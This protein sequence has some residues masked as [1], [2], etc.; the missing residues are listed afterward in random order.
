MI[1]FHTH[2]GLAIFPD[3]GL[4]PLTA[5]Q[6]VDSMNRRGIGMSVL[7]PLDS[8]EAY[9]TYS[10]TFEVLEAYK[11]YPE[12]LIPFCCVDPRRDKVAAQIKAYVNMGCRGFGEHKV[13]LA[14]DD[15]RS[16]RIYRIC[17]EM[18]LPIVM[19][20]DPGLND[21]EVGLPRLEKL[22]QEMPETNFVMHGP[23]W[24]AEISGDNQTRGGY[25]NGKVQPGGR[26]DILLREYPNIYGELSAGSG[27]NALV[28]DPDYTTGFLE[29]NWEKLIFGTDYLGA[30]QQLPIIRYIRELDMEKSKVY[31]I[32]RGNAVKLLNRGA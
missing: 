22:L 16:K 18:N 7:L 15:E 3:P 4:K 8:P 25:P 11:K 14:I 28:R 26:V 30:G 20:L 12:R 24:W 2:L 19:H 21:D 17:G 9:D 31:A 13:G 32:A 29:R 27:Y 6:L 1:D 23:G 5:E 10:T